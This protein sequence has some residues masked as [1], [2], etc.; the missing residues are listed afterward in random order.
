M[1]CFGAAV[2][3]KKVR[4]AAKASRNLYK[5]VRPISKGVEVAVPMARATSAVQTV[6]SGLKVA[7]TIN[8]SVPQIVLAGKSIAS[9][10][11]LAAYSL[12]FASVAGTIGGLVIAH[13]GLRALD[14]ISH[15]LENI[16][17]TNAAQLALEA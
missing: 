9:S 16:S 6:V 5:Y 15:Q 3:K 12:S 10:A 17:K 1:N 13:Q 8:E 11:S 4:Q 7:R 2:N 14:R